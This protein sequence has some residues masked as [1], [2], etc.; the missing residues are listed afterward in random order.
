MKIFIIK[1]LFIFVS[2]FILFK[3]TVGSL[4]SSYEEKFSYYFS[5]ANSTI[6]KDKMRKE[7]QSAIAKDKYLDD[8][9]AKLIGEFITKIKNEI[10]LK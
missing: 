6:I 7:M 9:D 3:A 10:S 4:I 8:D 1:S 2:I 5:K